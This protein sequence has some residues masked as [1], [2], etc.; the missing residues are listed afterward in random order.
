MGKINAAGLRKP[1]GSM[2]QPTEIG[3]ALRLSWPKAALE[4]ILEM[5]GIGAA[6]SEIAVTLA[7][8]GLRTP[9]GDFCWG[10]HEPNAACSESSLRTPAGNPLCA[11]ATSGL[12]SLIC[13]VKNSL[14][15]ERMRAEH[16]QRAT[17]RKSARLH[18]PQDPT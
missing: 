8:L 15:A 12:V 7:D 11:G 18:N 13:A 3:L 4:K 2:F 14:E 17:A 10:Q 9:S 1:D 16:D 6:P 5:D